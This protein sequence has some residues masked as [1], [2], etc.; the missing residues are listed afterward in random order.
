MNWNSIIGLVQGQELKQ[1][2]YHP[3]YSLPLTNAL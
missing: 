3:R 2:H 1:V